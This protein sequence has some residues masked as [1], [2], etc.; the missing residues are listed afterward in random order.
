MTQN[1]IVIIGSGVRECAILMKLRES[2]LSNKYEFY[3]VG[4]NENPYL[5]CWSNFIKVPNFSLTTLE[6][7]NI[8]SDSNIAAVIIGPEAPI[9]DGLTEV[10]TDRGI[11]CFAP[12]K[13][14]ARIET[15]KLFTRTFLEENIHDYLNPQFKSSKNF[16]N[17]KTYGFTAEEIIESLLNIKSEFK[18]KIVIKKDGL[19]GGKGV[20]V[21][22]DHFNL[23]ELNQESTLITDL[24]EYLKNRVNTVLVE[25]KLDGIEFSIM[26]LTNGINNFVNLDPVF[27]YK[28]LKNNDNGPNT[29]SM[30]AIILNK[31]TRNN[32]LTNEIVNEA[33]LVNEIV[34]K[35]LNEANKSIYKGIL[36]GSFMKTSDNELKVIEFNCRLGDPDGALSLLNSNL[37][38]LDF[39][40]NSKG[41]TG[42][43]QYKTENLSKD[44]NLVGVYCVP[45]PY[46]Q[47]PISDINYDIYFR[48]NLYKINKN[49][50][51]KGI[52]DDEV[53][54]LYGD[55]ILD[56]DRILTNKSRTIMLV[57]KNDYLYKAVNSVYKNIDDIVSRL[58]YRSDIGAKYI[59]KYEMA[60]V[61][62]T[63]ANNTLL[64]IKEN[65]KTTYNLNVKSELGDFGGVYNLNSEN[66]VSSIDGV[67]TKT[68]F[69]DKY[70]LKE[71][72]EGLGMD[73]V[74]H[75]IN[76]ILVMGAKP[77]FFLDYYGTSQLDTC[78]FASFIKGA[79]NALCIDE[80]TKVPLIGGETA[81][82]PTVYKWEK[83]D[84]VGCIIG[85]LDN[86]F[87]KYLRPPIKG[88]CLLGLRSQ[89]PHTNGFSLIN[90]I[91]WSQD[92]LDKNPIS[93]I[94]LE[95]FF[96]YLRTP[97]CSYYPI[98]KEILDKY[99]PSAFIRMCHITGG[100][101]YENL[102]RVIPKD[103][104]L[105]LNDNVL[106]ATYPQWCSII[107]TVGNIPKDE[108]YKVFNCGIGF[109]LIVSEELKT[110]LLKDDNFNIELIDLGCLK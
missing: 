106:K 13:K 4:C 15:S 20:Y 104:E 30:G 35:Y 54:L 101:L 49:T 31:N 66:L 23:T 44:K 27:D 45:E 8:L 3:S 34:I 67:G 55:C 72:Y 62:I 73:I 26:T 86:S 87:V 102:E 94:K 42:Y 25:E 85:K 84:I 22:G 78:Q 59:S 93:K 92:L 81:E 68:D 33:S 5:V 83:N 11:Y 7:L 41:D 2:K 21:E 63:N 80:N 61:S 16:Y 60:G 64:Q 52:I 18:S 75:S 28:R 100:G 99:G 76:D 103:L 1:K 37:D 14:N 88:D 109:V 89:G 79:C 56:K 43:I 48:N 57:V 9:A 105:H 65:L 70:F 10:L 46:P 110:H 91:P 108:M 97:H 51:Q 39:V 96:E 47:K 40:L 17:D 90:T 36:Y 82:M 98:V 24:V 77:L 74:N 50:L 95:G 107:E 38:L 71:D 29:G 53:V 58:K 19:C 12:D 69:V 32:F 6:N